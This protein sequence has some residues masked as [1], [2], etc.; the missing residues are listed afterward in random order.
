M[1]VRLKVLRPLVVA[2]ANRCIRRLATSRSQETPNSAPNVQV[3]LHEDLCTLCVSTAHDALE[4]VHDQ[5]YTVY[6]SSPWH[7]LYCKQEQAFYI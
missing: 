3:S 2:E 1:Y 7:N 4:E 6:R 5:L